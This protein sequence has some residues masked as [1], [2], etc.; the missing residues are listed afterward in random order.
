MTPVPITSALTMPPINLPLRKLAPHRKYAK[1]FLTLPDELLVKISNEVAPEDLPNFRLSCKTLANIAAK[2]FGE[3][4]LAHRRFMFTEYSLKG[5][6]DMTAHPIIGPCIRSILLGTVYLTDELTVLIDALESQK[7]TEDAE[8]MQ[9]GGL[10]FTRF[11]TMNQPSLLRAIRKAC[12]RANLRPELFEFDL[13][14]QERADGMK[15][16]LSDLLLTDGQSQLQARLDVCIREGYMDICILPSRNRLEFKQRPV[17]NQMLSIPECVRFD[18]LSLG[19]PMCDA[20]ASSSLTHLRM[21]SCSM[22]S[23]SFVGVLKSLAWALQVVELIDVAFWGDQCNIS[24]LDPILQCFKN[25]LRLHTLILDN[26][27]AMNKDY[28]DDTGILFA[29]GRYWHGPQQIHAGLDVLTGFDGNGWD[30][31]DMDDWFEKGIR[32]IEERA[33]SEY[34]YQNYIPDGSREGYLAYKA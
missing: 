10:P 27:R 5:L 15:T 8:A 2:H 1:K 22:W 12:R 24:N 33:S 28:S 26:V 7:I 6:I 34:Y 20:I 3:K 31:D 23:G 32:C 14:G 25:D 11:V 4:R 21:E 17:R 30:G 13:L 16:V 29:K 9:F 19:R 18:L